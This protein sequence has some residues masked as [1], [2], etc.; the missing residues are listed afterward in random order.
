MKYLVN[1]S[2]SVLLL[3]LCFSCTDQW[4]K[5]Y[6]ISSDE[7]YGCELVYEHLDELFPNQKVYLGRQKLYD[8][9][10]HGAIAED[11]VTPSD[12]TISNEWQFD[13]S[14]STNTEKLQ[15][16]YQNNWVMVGYASLDEQD[17]YALFYEL[18]Q[19][20]NIIIA[21]DELSLKLLKNTFGIES[22]DRKNEQKQLALYAE[23]ED[24]LI[25]YIKE[26]STINENKLGKP[27]LTDSAGNSIVELYKVG[28][29][30]LVVCTEAVLFTNFNLLTRDNRAI[31][32]TCFDDFDDKDIVWF[33]NYSS[34]HFTPKQKNKPREKTPSY[35]DFI[36]KNPALK[37]AFYLL[38]LGGLIY[39]L[40]GIKRKQRYIPIIHPPLNTTI[41]FVTMV[42]QLYRANGSHQQLAD[43]KILFFT[44]W[45]KER[46][47]LQGNIFTKEA[48]TLI[49][50]RSGVS[51]QKLI[52]LLKLIQEVK[53]SDAI[54]KDTLLTLNKQI[55]ALK[56]IL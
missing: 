47:H 41:K 16:T 54:T 48:F 8:N 15:K 51:Q 29:G 1:L 27:L 11:I 21:S 55:E 34:R 40:L 4:R 32:E 13:Y 30:K 6:S 28:Q 19:G 38:L 53:N 23:S 49:A 52:D 26:Y 10:R 44:E 18:Q 37:A 45:L 33:E 7:P 9:F 20:K 17:V 56:K 22:S 24:F 3:F 39:A 46:Y 12:L 35:L 25:D 50:K 31:I 2:Y 36:N 5:T 43:K 14:D 42:G